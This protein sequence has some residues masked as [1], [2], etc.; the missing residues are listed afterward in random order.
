MEPV[1]IDE[2]LSIT[3][4]CHC[5]KC[6]TEILF[7]RFTHNIVSFIDGGIYRHPNWNSSHFVKD[8]D[9]SLENI[10]SDV[11]TILTGDLNIDIIKI[12]NEITLE[13]VS[14]LM[15]YGYLPFIALPSRITEYSATCI[16]HIFIKY[17]KNSRLQPTNTLSGMF[18]CDI[19]DH[20]PCIVSL[21]CNLCV[22]N[23]NRLK[24]QL[25]RDKNCRKFKE[26]MESYEW[27]AL[28][29]SSPDLYRSF[30]SV[31]KRFYEISF[32]MVKLSRSRMR[33]KPWTTKA[34]KK[35]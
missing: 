7:V 26:L 20:L 8:L 12:E 15:S 2:H 3:K 19:T 32:P 35:A 6:E 30:I 22:D 33:D 17:A 25:F 13:Y 1:Y 5:V 10:G 23:V 31:V 27:N 11:T 34:L 4:S 24:A 18:Y 21:K 29:L 9:R 14:T 16:D 28:Y